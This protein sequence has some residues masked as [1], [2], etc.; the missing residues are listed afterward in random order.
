MRL[1]VAFIAVLGVVG[2]GQGMVD[3]DQE[4][5]P[6]LGGD[7]GL[8]TG[9]SYADT[10][11]P[12][13]GV[14][15]GDLINY[16]GLR[17]VVPEAGRTT[18]TF[19]AFPDGTMRAVAVAH[20]ESGTAQVVTSGPE[21]EELDSAPVDAAG[22]V[23]SSWAL[24]TPLAACS[25]STYVTHRTFSNGVTVG[26]LKWA[27]PFQW[28]FKAS[29]TPS[30]LDADRVE[31]SL[32]AAVGDIVNSRNSCG[33]ADTVSAAAQYMGRTTSDGKNVVSFA[34]F[35]FPYPF[36]ATSVTE[37]PNHPGHA[38]WA[39]VTFA[40]GWKYSDGTTA[41]AH[42]FTGRTVPTACKGIISLEGTAAH[43]L[44]HVFGL[45]DLYACAHENLTMYGSPAFC[46]LKQATL[47]RGDVLGLRSL[48]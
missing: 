27:G 31:A 32:R 16:Q 26:G 42:W 39:T 46:S 36:A 10:A 3:D 5:N 14:L 1:A 4:E 18:T 45:V 13:T 9:R 38:G 33:M 24:C 20:L 22:L 34:R 35:G 30:T 48:Y 7:I 41:R 44:G 23:S 15:A 47:G 12:A 43:E 40:S 25:D 6:V 28:Y 19:L 21:S 8:L 37:D 29:S 2:C 11:I 17:L